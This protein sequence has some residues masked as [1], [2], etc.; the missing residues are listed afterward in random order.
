MDNAPTTA[1]VSAQDTHTALNALASHAAYKLR[2]DALRF[3]FQAVPPAVLPRLKRPNQLVSWLVSIATYAPAEGSADTSGADLRALVTRVHPLRGKALSV[4]ALLVRHIK[5]IDSAHNDADTLQAT[6]AAAFTLD[7]ARP[8]ILPALPGSG[9]CAK[10]AVLGAAGTSAMLGSVLLH[11]AVEVWEITAVGDPQE[12][13]EE[14]P[15]SSHCQ[16]V[17]SGSGPAAGAEKLSAVLAACSDSLA[18]LLTRLGRACAPIPGKT[19]LEPPAG[20]ASPQ[21]LSRVLVDVSKALAAAAEARANMSASGDIAEPLSSTVVLLG[22]VPPGTATLLQQLEMERLQEQEQEQG[23][24]ASTEAQT[25]Q[26]AALAVAQLTSTGP[27]LHDAFSAAFHSLVTA[28]AS[29]G[30]HPGTGA[31]ADTNTG[32]QQTSEAFSMLVQVEEAT[33]AALRAHITITPAAADEGE[34]EDNDN[35]MGGSGTNDPTGVRRAE[36]LVGMLGSIWEAVQGT[37]DPTVAPTTTAALDYSSNTRDERMRAVTATITQLQQALQGGLRVYGRTAEGKP[38]YSQ[39]VTGEMRTE[40][41]DACTDCRSGCIAALQELLSTNDGRAWTRSNADAFWAFGVN[42]MKAPTLL[43][44]AYS[45]FQDGVLTA[46]MQHDSEAEETAQKG[47]DKVLSFLK[48]ALIKTEEYS[49][50]AASDVMQA[51]ELLGTVGCPHYFAPVSSASSDNDED[52]DGGDIEYNAELFA[53]VV[54]AYATQP[55]IVVAK[56][57]PPQQEDEEPPLLNWRMLCLCAM[58]II[59]LKCPLQNDKQGFKA[60][61]RPLSFLT[62][63][64]SY[65]MKAIMIYTRYDSDSEDC[66]SG[67]GSDS[68]GNSKYKKQLKARYGTTDVQFL[69]QV[70]T[71]VGSVYL[72]AMAILSGNGGVPRGPGA[73]FST[74]NSAPVNWL[75]RWGKPSMQSAEGATPADPTMEES[76]STDY[77]TCIPFL[78]DVLS[79]VASGAGRP[80]VYDG[81]MMQQCLELDVVRATLGSLSQL[82]LAAAAQEKDKSSPKSTECWTQ[83]VETCVSLALRA[84]GVERSHLLIDAISSADSEPSAAIARSALKKH[85]S[86]VGPIYGYA[87]EVILQVADALIWRTQQ[88]QPGSASGKDALSLAGQLEALLPAQL[89]ATKIAAAGSFGTTQAIQELV[90]AQL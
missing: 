10:A 40:M 8:M 21:L 45:A 29:S 41:R 28:I 20:L 77:A 54:E 18:S 58:D 48:I 35:N 61:A 2:L 1:E 44:P 3:F 82:L 31:N 63:L 76:W 84:G 14:G 22:E 15:H 27:I 5:A 26:T 11:Q 87:R 60:L 78:L 85:C 65:E 71:Q 67:C 49:L 81:D 66:G 24:G 25:L 62:R 42:V 89:D 55:R 36:S 47:V 86:V 51:M 30:V 72:A 52:E 69:Q 43:V 46:R 23:V 70:L 38:E 56:R 34:G 79:A 32:E 74:T 57:G 50:K 64:L 83:V 75:E 19:K 59:L 53:A 9:D 80:C 17:G 73:E 88:P 16:A 12:D 37:A 33:V 68:N 6:V 4:L 39:G 13:R 7:L 90:K